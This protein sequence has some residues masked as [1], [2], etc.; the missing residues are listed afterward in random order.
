MGEAKKR[1]AALR[2]EFSRVLDMWSF[3]PS[4]AE[5]RT[6]AEVEALP[7]VTVERESAERLEWARMKPRLCHDNCAWYERNDPTGTAK[8]VTG[9][10]REPTGN[11][12]LHAVVNVGGEYRCITPIPGEPSRFQFIPDPDIQT[13]RQDDNKYR[14]TRKGFEIGAGIR[15]DPAK[16]LRHIEVIR[17]RLA[18]GMDPYKAMDLRTLD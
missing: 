15:P 3:P 6:V 1:D 7:A 5:A 8:S 12:V 10:M 11:Y 18:S 17:E 16:T 2:A 13:V 14:H 9:W 4:E